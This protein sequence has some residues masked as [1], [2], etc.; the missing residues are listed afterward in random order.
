M[1]MFNAVSVHAAI[2]AAERNALIALYNSTDGDNWKNNSGWK[3]GTLEA[4]GFGPVGS[5]GSWYGVYV[6]NNHVTTI[7]LYANSLTG[8]LP[9]ELGDL[10]YLENLS[11][12]LNRIGGTIP[13]ELGNLSQLTY[14]SLRSN[15]LSGTIPAELGNLDQLETLFL[16][17]NQLTGS[18]PPEL[19]NLSQ[20]K[21]CRL[22]GNQLSGNIPTELT[23]LSQL[24][25][26]WLHTNQLSGN[27]PRELGTLS[28][29]NSLWLGDNQLSGS[30]PTE[31]G[32]LSQLVSLTL[33]N[34]RLSGSIPAELGN[35]SQMNYLSLGQNNLSG[36]IPPQLGNLSRLK[37][38]YLYENSLSGS[39]PTELG[40]LVQLSFLYLNRNKLSGQIPLSMANLTG[41]K[42]EQVN[43]GYNALYNHDEELGTFLTSHVGNWENSQT[44]APSNVSALAVSSS[45]IRLTWDPIAYS[46]NSG[47][48]KVYYSSFSGGPRTYAG[49]TVDKTVSSYDVTGLSAGTKYYFVIQTQT[50]DSYL[51]NDNMLVSEYSE[52]VSA[53]TLSPLLEKDPPF[54][55]FATPIDGL[56]AYGSIPVTGWALDDSGVESVKIYRELGKKTVYIG[57]AVFVE[58][59]RPDVAA[60]YPEYPG[61]TRA[62]WGY[63][64]LTNFLPDHGNGTFV[65]HAVATDVTGKTTLLG[66]KTIQCD[67]ENAV[68]P[69]GAIDTP[70]Q[71]GIAS[72]SEFINWGWALTP[73]PN[74]IPTDGSTIDVWVDG[75]KL[76]HPTYNLY[77]EDIATLFPG[78]A[79]SEGAV[80]YYY[81]ANNTD[82]I[83]SRYFTIQNQS[84]T[85]AQTRT[86]RRPHVQWDVSR[87]PRDYSTPLAIRKG[88]DLSA[89]PQIFYPDD[90]GAVNITIGQL[91]RLE[92]HFAD[93]TVNITSLPP[94]STMTDEGKRFCWQPGAASLGW[95]RLVFLSGNKKGMMM[96]KEIY[97]TI[98]P[99][100][101]LKK[102]IMNAE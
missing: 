90:Q 64:L 45:T 54:G 55:S 62:G 91:E 50:D 19:G 10:A 17:W 27:I 53:V 89:E 46:R 20:L 83:G 77:R 33:S 12:Y 47:G 51:W 38:L 68:K 6:K 81:N 102:L 3:D 49:K 23:N 15:Q 87:I 94:G 14:L 26:L 97:I 92:I 13:A 9:A 82:G 59:A 44:I 63:M 65:L 52:E 57:D 31:I 40:N 1:A 60:A 41:L 8:T 84:K 32:N 11:L 28:L 98:V 72:G 71:G 86:M 74:Q 96:R 70:A 22:N 75:V 7:N 80:G 58:G 67:N 93:E 18:I 76:G 79:N 36:N 88:Y 37:W 24:E 101:K 16:N 21:S 2:P 95:Y 4:D 48:Y 78:Y 29:L 35:L 5:E 25:T 73:W 43:I 56:V 34:N 61:N 69:F 100:R 66:T 85:A 99:I 42:P 39:I 30:I